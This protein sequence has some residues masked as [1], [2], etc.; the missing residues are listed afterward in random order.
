MKLSNGS[1]TKME[2]KKMKTK[3]VLSVFIR[4]RL[5]P[6]LLQHCSLDL[7]R[8]QSIEKVQRHHLRA[9]TNKN[10]HGTPFADVTYLS[11]LRRSI[12][13]LFCSDPHRVNSLPWTNQ[14]F[15]VVSHSPFMSQVFCCSIILLHP[16]FLVS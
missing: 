12:E 6:V 9:S 11:T 5:N 13:L 10:V 3:S 2:M 15:I 16:P 14:I 8:V 1:K 7:R 4:H